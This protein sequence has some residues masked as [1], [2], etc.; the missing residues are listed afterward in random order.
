MKTIAIL[1]GEI[2]ENAPKDDLNTLEQ[3]K[4]VERAL[5][6]LGY[7]T[8]RVPLSLNI[9]KAWNILEKLQPYCVFN[10]VDSVNAKCAFGHLGALI[11]EQLKLPYTGAD[12]S[13]LFLTTDKQMAKRWMKSQGIPAPASI[14]GTPPKSAF[15]KGQR[16]I[17][18]SSLEDGSIGLA[19]DSVVGDAKTLARILKDRRKTHG[20]EWFAEQYIAGREFYISLLSV[21]G[22]PTVLAPC[23]ATF[24]NYPA[25]YSRIVDYAAK[26]E[27]QSMEWKQIRYVLRH[28]KKDAA[29]IRKLSELA[30]QCWNA[31]G[32]T[33]G[34][35][36]IDFRVDER[37]NPYVLEMNINPCLSMR[38]DFYWMAEKSGY[39]YTSM[40]ETIV[41]EAVGAKSTA[42]RA[43]HG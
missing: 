15:G 33:K 25:H 24:P 7:K 18:K 35:L 26:W 2:P 9:E 21:D 43:S 19:Q 23:E 28:K 22:R 27:N 40:I 42:L 31:L 8:T 16:Y 29:L 11:P 10:L 20:G 4:Y 36:R 13:A 5:A 6:K 37:E 3:C 39:D 32:L 41:N 34:H 14:S 17:V 1:H 12:S 30:L 38:S